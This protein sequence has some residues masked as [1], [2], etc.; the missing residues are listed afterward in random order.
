MVA[1]PLAVR[2]QGHQQGIQ[3]GQLHQP[4][5]TLA[6][7]AYSVC[8]LSV[9]ALQQGHVAQKVLAVLGQALHHLPG[10]VVGHIG[11]TA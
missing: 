7:A 4:L 11:D 5:R 2:I 10:Q 6:T 3:M 9:E 1:E 8:Q